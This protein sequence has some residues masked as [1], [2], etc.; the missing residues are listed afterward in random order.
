MKSGTKIKELRYYI[1]LKDV[2]LLAVSAF[3]GPQA[4]LALINKR[5]VEGKRYIN[6]EELKDLNSLCQLLPGPTST[7]TIT[8][9]G[10][11]L[12][13]PKLAWLTLLVWVLPSAILMTSIV[14]LVSISGTTIL[15]QGLLKYIPDMGLGFIIYAALNIMRLMLKRPVH[16]IIWVGSSIATV[17]ISYPLIY[18]IVLLCGGMITNFTSKKERREIK[19]QGRIKWDGF[20]LFLAVFLI[21]AFFGNVF[22]IFPILLFENIYRHGSLVFGGGNVLVPMMY[23]QFV[24]FKHYM[25]HEVFMTGVG[26]VQAMPGPVFSF[27][28]YAGGMS[29]QNFGMDGQLLGC[30][31]GTVAIF[32]PGIFLIFFI[33]PI[34]HRI[35][36]R[37]TVMRAIEG[38]NAAS[39]GLISSAA[40]IMS[41]SVQFSA[42]NVGV[43]SVTI[44]LL[45]IQKLPPLLIVIGTM[46][47]GCFF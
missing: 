46:L 34:W 44:L 45:L 1:F 43:I 27:A 30:L 8:S 32:L 14:L 40:F 11:K 23:D 31:V 17:L 20:V 4:H 19:P 5:L 36:G 12:G 10:Y 7:Q 26:L 41:H 28:T 37:R 9:I 18:P 13:G 25:S 24:L 38:I 39:A 22:H 6:A 2:L 21:A 35:N 3:G 47:L 33:Y 29:M 42:I 15:P 16:W